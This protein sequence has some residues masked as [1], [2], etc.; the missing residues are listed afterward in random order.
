MKLS[1]LTAFVLALFF[2]SGCSDFLKEEN[3]S[4]IISDEYYATAE[5]YEKLV[6]AAYS[7]LRTVYAEPWVFC[8]GTDMYVEGR[9]QL[10]DY[11]GCG[12]SHAHG[13]SA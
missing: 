9:T 6:N 12:R 11:G 1:K 13:A 2:L 8:A 3:K 4:N 5:G 7:S 10:Y